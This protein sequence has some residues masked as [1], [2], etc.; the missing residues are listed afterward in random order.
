M[1]QDGEQVQDEAEDTAL[2]D[3]DEA[4]DDGVVEGAAE[5]AAEVGGVPA[6]PVGPV[7]SDAL[8]RI[9]GVLRLRGRAAAER[10]ARGAR[11][12]MDMYQA[13]RDLDKLYQKLGREVIR[14][15]EAGEVNHPGLQKGV[16]RVR[17]QEAAVTLAAEI[18]RA[19]PPEAAAASVEDDI[20]SGD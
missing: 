9:V 2:V 18:A 19:A 10:G 1:S 12:R 5:E 8:E 4:R 6:E 16:A 15:V 20:D 11:R 17:K 3:G 14:L 13:R 7:I